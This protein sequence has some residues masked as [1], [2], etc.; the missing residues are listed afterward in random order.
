LAEF[1]ALAAGHGVTMGELFHEAVGLLEK[2]KG[3]SQRQILIDYLE[4]HKPALTDADVRRMKE[5]SISR[6]KQKKR[7]RS[8]LTRS[9]SFQ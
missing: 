9:I 5:Q 3:K 8:F 7:Q 4:S 6:L 2:H 1:K